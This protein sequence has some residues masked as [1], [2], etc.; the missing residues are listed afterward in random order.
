MMDAHWKAMRKERRYWRAANDCGLC[1]HGDCMCHKVQYHAPNHNVIPAPKDDHIWNKSA[2]EV[3]AAT[4]AFVRE[5]HE[6]VESGKERLRDNLKK[7]A[8]G[9]LVHI[10]K[11][12]RAIPWTKEDDDYWLKRT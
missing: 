2:G 12:L 8:E 7:E 9:A 11:E 5:C 6:N 4:Y 1:W 3:I 10:P